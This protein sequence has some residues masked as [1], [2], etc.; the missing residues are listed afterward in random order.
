MNT[1]FSSFELEAEWVRHLCS[2][3][4]FK[5]E[6]PPKAWDLKRGIDLLVQLRRGGEVGV[7]GVQ[8]KTSVA[9]ALGEAAK[10]NHAGGR[11]VPILVGQPAADGADILQLSRTGLWIH[12]EL[13][14]NRFC[15]DLTREVELW[16]AQKPWFWFPV[17]A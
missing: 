8:V 5:A 6:P 1:N 3:L 2:V 15:Q 7:L 12:P 4:G 13:R 10:C 17:A 14:E 16:E 9:G 11:F